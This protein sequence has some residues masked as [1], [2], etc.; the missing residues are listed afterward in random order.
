MNEARG[1]L[2][3]ILGGFSPSRGLGVVWWCTFVNWRSACHDRLSG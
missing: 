3:W 1:I 2:G